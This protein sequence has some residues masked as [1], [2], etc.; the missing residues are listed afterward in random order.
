MKSNKIIYREVCERWE[1]ASC[2]EKL[3]V[4]QKFTETAQDLPDETLDFLDLKG[5]ATLV[6]QSAAQR[7]VSRQFEAS[8]NAAFETLLSVRPN[9][10][11]SVISD[12]LYMTANVT[13]EINNHGQS[14][15]QPLAFTKAIGLLTKIAVMQPDT[16]F[17][18]DSFIKKNAGL[19]GKD[20]TG[21]QQLQEIINPFNLMACALGNE[22][23]EAKQRRT[24]TN[25]PQTP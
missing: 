17:L 21:W 16:F 12:L 11:N 22:A 7:V 8:A 15:E 2:A 23:S 4:L 10:F 3:L 24:D 1:Q 18:H 13:P 20:A 14:H 9:I 19:S 5:F 6:F 25:A